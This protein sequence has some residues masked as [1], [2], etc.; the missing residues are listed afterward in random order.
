V[1]VDDVRF[2]ECRDDVGLPLEPGSSLRI[3]GEFRRQQLEGDEPAVVGGVDGAVDFSH[4]AGADETAQ[5]VRPELRG[6]AQLGHEPTRAVRSH[7]RTLRSAP[8]V[9]R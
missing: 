1:H 5:L 4:A 9:T 3:V 7:S 6:R 8:R 2:R